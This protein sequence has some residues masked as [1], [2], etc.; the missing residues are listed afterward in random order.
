MMTYLSEHLGM[1]I[2]LGASVLYIV[3]F[4]AAIHAVM[5]AR[6]SQGAIAWAVALL[7][8]PYL[9]VPLYAIFG[10]N[11]FQGYVKA[12]KAQDLKLEKIISSLEEIY[13][14]E[15][16]I[17]LEGEQ[18]RYNA[19]AQLEN[20]PFTLS[21]D[22]ELL[23]DGKA[24]FDAIFEGIQA[25]EKY[26]LVQFFIVKDDKLGRE[27]KNRLVEKAAQGIRIC[28][29]YD[30]I[31]SHSLPTSYINELKQAGVDIR[32]FRTTQGR[33][34]RF[35]VN[36]RNHRKI[37]IVDGHTAYVGGHNVG[38]E[39]LGEHP[40]LTPWRDTHVRVTGPT[41]IAVQLSFV[42]DWYWAAHNVPDLLWEV[43]VYEGSV[44]SLVIPSGPADDQDTCSL[45][46]T[47]LINSARQRI[48]IVSPY[49]VPD[50]SVLSALKLAALRG[51]DVRVMIPEN[52]DHKTVYLAGFACLQEIEGTGVRIY[53]Y[54][55]G[56]LHQKVFLVDDDLAGVGTANL[57]NRSLRLN[58]EI[59]L[60]FADK[61]FAAE[62][63]TMLENDFMECREVESGEL[64]R[65]PYWF[66]VAVR[67]ARLLSPVL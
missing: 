45:M 54:R 35:Q 13:P 27:L 31:G 43:D 65:K 2:G 51:V 30:E 29:L 33:A 64:G 62:V 32:P 60:A 1:V 4:V 28:F 6:T 18:E 11:R 9:T 50:E 25:A 67:V 52:P 44:K 16:W 8:F 12:R 56:F 42:V 41:V 15:Q 24:T 26:I 53:R 22:A 46:F 36:F 39:Y 61:G 20:I 17:T 59:T 19:L 3:A 49:F 23:V 10:R 57:D 37:V 63:E 40:K 14:E 47:Q 7:S 48:W 66:Q 5:K 38:D 55:Q 34:N 58:F 21:G